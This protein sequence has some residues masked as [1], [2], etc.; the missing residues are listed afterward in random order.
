MTSPTL[1]VVLQIALLAVVLRL[2]KHNNA[3]PTFYKY[4]NPH[5]FFGLFV[6]LFFI[7]PEIY[8]LTHYYYLDGFPFAVTE[9]LFIDGAWLFTVFLGFV[10]VGMLLARPA[11]VEAPIT[12]RSKMILESIET[13]HLKLLTV[14]LASGVFANLY[15]AMQLSGSTGFRSQLVKSAS[16]QALTIIVYFGSFAAALLTAYFISVK[17]Y[18][19]GAAVLVT[20]SA[21]VLLTESRGR[22][23]WPAAIT[24]ILLISRRAKPPFARLAVIG[25]LTLVVLLLLDPVNKYL[26]SGTP[27]QLSD[28]FNIDAPFQRRNFDGMSNFVLISQSGLTEPDWSRWLSGGNV[29]FMTKFFPDVLA[30]GVAFGVTIPGWLYMAGGV[31]GVCAGGIFYGMLLG[32]INRL[33]RRTIAPELLVGY[34]FAMTWLGA[35]GGDFVGS[36]DKAAASFAP[37]VVYW[38]V[39]NRAKT[40]RHAVDRPHM[41]QLSMNEV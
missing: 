20:F 41:Q 17:R 36:L 16:G 37:A 25:V 34:L 40:G 6:T 23:L 31:F 22:I 13:R 8:G 29:D 14:F 10:C 28:I 21:S 19:L 12:D 9:R 4:F 5:A 18:W 15:L 39:C 1:P 24:V 35:V 27:I 30:S 2:G 7:I 3:D 32:Q 11:R 33:V 38:L 26:A